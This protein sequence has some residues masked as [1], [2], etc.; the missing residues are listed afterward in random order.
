[1][2]GID[3]LVLRE[4]AH[5]VQSLTELGAEV[6][7]VVGGGNFIRGHLSARYGIQRVTADQV[8]MLGTVMNGLALR[9]VLEDSGQRTAI[10]S[11]VEMGAIVASYRRDAALNDLRDGRMVIFVAGLGSPFFTTDTTAAVRGLEMGAEVFLKATK[12]DG[13]YDKDPETD[14]EAIKFDTISYEEVL[15]LHLK[16]IDSAAVALCMDHQL[17]IIVFKIGGKGVMRRLAQGEGVGTLIG[18]MG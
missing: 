15:R 5:E 3:P 18:R 4:L 10:Y 7:I 13:V 1:V 11:A 6:A 12:V 8:G 2:S 17:P 14:P 9:D 16:V